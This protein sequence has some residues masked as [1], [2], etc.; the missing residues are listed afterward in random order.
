MTKIY[1]DPGH[2][3]NDPGAV[4]NG[5]REKDLTLEIGLKVRDI[6]LRNYENVEVRMSRTADT[7]LSLDQRTNDANTWG[8][9]FLISIHINAGGEK[10]SKATFTM[11][12][13]LG[14]QKPNV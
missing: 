5:L 12:L 7:T 9:D 1:L 13:I 11:A 3:G 6:L 2:G 14:N 8:A 4:G 10:V